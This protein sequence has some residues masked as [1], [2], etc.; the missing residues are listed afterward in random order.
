MTSS[1]T[2]DGSGNTVRPGAQLPV[3]GKAGPPGYRSYSGKTGISLVC[4]RVV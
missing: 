1:E 3:G 4:V 2:V